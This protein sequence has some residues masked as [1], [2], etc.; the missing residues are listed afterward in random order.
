ML[1][2]CDC[3]D[4]DSDRSILHH[5]LSSANS[6]FIS[7]SSAR[8]CEAS[9]WAA[10][11]YFAAADISRVIPVSMSSRRLLIRLG[12]IELMEFVTFAKAMFMD[13]T[14]LIACFGYFLHLTSTLTDISSKDM[15]KEYNNI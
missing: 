14:S 4:V 15:I 1:L 13:F 5:F 6:M 3:T 7:S 12:F 9:S 10:S 11:T 2:T 8:D